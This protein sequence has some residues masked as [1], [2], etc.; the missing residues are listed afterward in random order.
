[1]LNF[2][3]LNQEI[4]IRKIINVEF[5][6]VAI[7][8]SNLSDNIILFMYDLKIINFFEYEFDDKRRSS[9]YPIE[10]IMKL[11]IAVKMKIKMSLFNMPYSIKGH[12]V[13]AK[14]GFNIT[15]ING[16]LKD[17]LII[18]SLL[19]RLLWKYEVS[20]LFSAYNEMVQK[21]IMPKLKAPKTIHILDCTD[22]ELNLD[23]ANYKGDEVTKNKHDEVSRE[24][25][26]GTIRGL[27]E[28]ICFDSLKTHDL[29]LTKDMIKNST[30]FKD[31]DV[32][33]N[34]H[35]FLIETQLTF[36]KTSMELI[37]TCH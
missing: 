26:L 27:I 33:I 3:R 1:M 23:N 8:E 32:L 21:Y 36:W 25:K 5:D 17:R 20:E 13:L 19:R 10:L 4:V 28:K 12:W 31:G 30:I 14:L 24:Y 34:V 22:L 16:S 2:W 37:L 29:N 6:N 11:A 35:G 7:S 9:T 15:D 18:E